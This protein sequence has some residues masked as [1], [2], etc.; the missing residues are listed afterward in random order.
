[1]ILLGELRERGDEQRERKRE[2]RGKGQLES[3]VDLVL[4]SPSSCLPKTPNNSE[5]GSIYL[6]HRTSP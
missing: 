1:M 6:P 5:I 4:L 3:C 2:G